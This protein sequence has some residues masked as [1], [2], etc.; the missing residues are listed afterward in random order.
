MRYLR[1]GK[2]GYR[3]GSGIESAGLDALGI[4][5][6]YPKSTTYHRAVG[7]TQSQRLQ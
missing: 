5:S 1:T 7:G 6:Q 2:T 4:T 3:R